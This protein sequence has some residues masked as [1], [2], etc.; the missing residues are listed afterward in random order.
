[1][2]NLSPREEYL[3]YEYGIDPEIIRLVDEAEESLKDRFSKLDEV[4]EY[5]Q[6][7][8]LKA[9]QSN[10]ISDM[11]FA[12]NTGYGYDDVGREGVEKVFADVF[13]AEDALVRT[14]I[15]N[16]THAISTAMLGALRPGEKIIYATGMPYDTMQSVIG[17]NPDM[18]KKGDGSLRDYGIQFDYVDLK[19]DNSI[20][21]DDLKSL[22]DDNTRVIAVQ[23]SMGYGWRNS[24]SVNQIELLCDF[25]RGLDRDDL[26]VLVDN[27][28]C[29]FIDEREPI[30]AGAD[31]VCGSLIKNPG[32]GLALSGGYI[33]GKKELIEQISFRLTCPGIGRECGLTYGQ[34][35]NMLQGLFFAPKVT[36]GALKGAMLLGKTFEKLGFPICPGVDDVR[37][38][39]IQAVELGRPEAVEAFCLGVQQAAPIDSHVTPVPAPMPGYED[40]VIMAAGTFVQGSSI[41]LSCD[42]PMREP[43]NAY[44][45][46]GLTY[47]HSK[48]GIIKSLD[49]LKKSGII[50]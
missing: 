12:W 35:R 10:Y 21:L 3:I 27:C 25:V 49:N 29:E 46:G 32:G 36:N 30:A 42:A 44:F 40:K 17:V 6:L 37:S 20:D 2:S 23:R 33:A 5:H 50:K 16:G 48:F 7:R 9:F 24:I 4:T 26:I 28:Y 22:V 15:V 13:M 31:L 1:M 11:H 18:Y 38:D 19:E 39:I 14:N 47:E 41:E 45:Q 8:V 34:S 43:Y